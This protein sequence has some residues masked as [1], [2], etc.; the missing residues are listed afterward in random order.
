M[1]IQPERWALHQQ[2]DTAAQTWRDGFCLTDWCT[3]KRWVVRRNPR[4]HD[5]WLMA[6]SSK[7]VAWEIAGVVPVCPLCGTNLSP[8]VG[9]VGEVPGVANN[10]LAAYTRRLAA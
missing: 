8:H 9:G 6:V 4:H 2:N 7:E 1:I 5:L 3:A 10:P